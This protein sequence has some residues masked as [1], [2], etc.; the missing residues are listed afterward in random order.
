M[1][2]IADQLA[3]WP[4]RFFMDDKFLSIYCLLFGL[5]FSIQML[6]A[7]ARNSPFAFVYL[8]R[9]FVL[10][11]IGAVHSILTNESILA[12]YAMVGVVLLI[13][14]RLPLKI[15]PVLA[16]LCVLISQTR[17]FVIKQKNEEAI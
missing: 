17:E 13:V 8:R 3:Y 10:Y 4:I 11:L 6:R 7:E 15:L 14:H 1:T 9:L 2:G 12:D 16:I 5:G